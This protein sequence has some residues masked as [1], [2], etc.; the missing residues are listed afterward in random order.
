ML[1]MRKSCG[2]TCIFDQHHQIGK[3]ISQV[4]FSLKIAYLVAVSFELWMV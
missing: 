1:A 2:D 4:S 3:I